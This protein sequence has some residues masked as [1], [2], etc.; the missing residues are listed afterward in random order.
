MKSVPDEIL[1]LLSVFAA[2]TPPKFSFLKHSHLA[3]KRCRALSVW[4]PP[5]TVPVVFL[6]GPLDARLT[7][8]EAKF[9]TLSRLRA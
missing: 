6:G 5:P 3:D 4:G 9:R 7:T 1:H 2:S 8:R